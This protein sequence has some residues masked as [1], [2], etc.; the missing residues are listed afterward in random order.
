VRWPSS[1]G[2]WFAVGVMLAAILTPAAAFA[3][4]SIVR[5]QGGAGNTANVDVAHQ[6][7]TVENDPKSTFHAGYRILVPGVCQILDSDPSRGMIVRQLRLA[8]LN[9]PSFDRF[10]G[11]ALYPNSTCAGAYVLLAIPE[12]VGTI[13][14]TF[15]PGVPIAAGDGISMRAFGASYAGDAE[16][17]GYLVPATAVP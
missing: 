12:R 9:S 8:T 5:V 14:E 15:E 17:S 16:V 3:A 11:A 6:L 2:A 4:A 10:H 1:N 13:T 7:L